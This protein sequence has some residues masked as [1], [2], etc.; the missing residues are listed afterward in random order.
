[1]HVNYNYLENL[2]LLGV[3]RH[4]PRVLTFGRSLFKG[5]NLEFDKKNLF[6]YIIQWRSSIYAVT[7]WRAH[8]QVK[9]NWE[10][11]LKKNYLFIATF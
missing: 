4:H 3:I 10:I 11:N 8:R 5:V 1:M 2:S 6:I 7:P 9:K